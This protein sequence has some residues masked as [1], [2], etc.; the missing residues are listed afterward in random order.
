MDDHNLERVRRI[1]RSFKDKE[2]DGH[3]TI[4]RLYAEVLRA[5]AKDFPQFRTAATPNEWEK[6]YHTVIETLHDIAH[7]FEELDRHPPAKIY[8]DYSDPY[9]GH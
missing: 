3:Y 7:E 2:S 5:T 8:D 6:G 4:K 9:G 1:H